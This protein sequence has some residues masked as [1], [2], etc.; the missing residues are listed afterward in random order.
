MK[1][2]IYCLVYNHEKYVRSALEGFVNQKTDFEYEV[3]VHDDASTDDSAKIIAEYAKKYPEIIKPIYQKENQYSQGIRIVSKYICPVV[4]GEYIA[5]CEGDD[6]WVDSSKL[7]R[8]VDFLDSHL[9]YTA[10]VHNS[11]RKNMRTG[12][13]KLMYSHKKDEDLTFFDV[14][15]RGGCCYQTSSLMYRREYFDNRPAFFDKAVGFG[16]YP[17]AIYLALSGKI[18]FLN[19]TMSVYRAESENSWSSRNIASMHKAATSYGHVANMLESV[20]EYTEGKYQEILQELVLENRYLSL[21]F[22][23]KYDELR[24]EPFR[25]IYKKHSF[26]Y[27]MKTYIKQYCHGIYHYYRKKIYARR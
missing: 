24:K 23:E 25:K 18:R 12:E 16:D 6:Y 20:N 13:E 7:Q 4:T 26:S 2:S 14:V 17:L 8:Q 1:V 15:Q 11:L 27:R 3:F 19:R 9:D 5:V 22:D 10:C 21:Y